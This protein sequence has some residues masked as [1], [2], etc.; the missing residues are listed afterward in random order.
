MAPEVINNVDRMKYEAQKYDLW[1][2]GVVLYVMLVGEYPFSPRDVPAGD[3]RYQEIVRSRVRELNYRL[4]NFL[5]VGA[6]DLIKGCLSRVQNRFSIEQIINH[7]W[8][9]KRL[10]VAALHMNDQLL[11]SDSDMM[12]QVRQ[13]LPRNFNAIE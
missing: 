8:F 2:C 11:R 12:Q 9:K 3:P 13:V 6:V 1:S 10:P 4:P 7:P 5:S